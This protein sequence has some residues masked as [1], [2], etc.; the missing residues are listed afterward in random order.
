M[1]QRF[2][3]LGGKIRI[4]QDMDDPAALDDSVRTDHFCYGKHGGHLHDGNTSL[5]ELGR[6]RSTA[7]SGRASRR[8]EN[9]CLDSLCFEFLRDFT[10][11]PAT[12]GQRVG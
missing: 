8:G 1:P 11:Q 12:V 2:F 9:D 10:S 3:L 4:S 5:F 6:D 7:A